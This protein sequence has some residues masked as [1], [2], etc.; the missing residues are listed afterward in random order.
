MAPLISVIVPTYNRTDLLL[1]RCLPSVFAQTVQDFEVLVIGDG[2]EQATVDAMAQL[3]DPRVRFWN[4]P[5]YDY[6]TDHENRWAIIGLAS[7][8]FGLDNA[9]GEWIAVLADD[10]EWTPD[11]HEVLLKAAAICDA[12][13]V[14]GQSDTYKNGQETGQIY[15]GWPPGG[16]PFCNGANLYRSRLPY[17]YDLECRRARGLNGDEDLWKR[18]VEGGVRFHYVERVVHHYHRNYP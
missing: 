5:H 14:Y 11:H 15:G 13:H 8:N 16:P 1:N 12:E 18:M 3:A 7:L 9:R 6:P 10:D 2:T 4:L 17:R